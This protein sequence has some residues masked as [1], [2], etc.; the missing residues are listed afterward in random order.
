MQT[1]WC[2]GFIQIHNNPALVEYYWSPFNTTE[3][4]KG[5]FCIVQEVAETHHFNL[6]ICV[7]DRLQGRCQD[8]SWQGEGLN[9]QRSPEVDLGVSRK[10]VEAQGRQRWRWQWEVV[11]RERASRG[12]VTSRNAVEPMVNISNVAVRSLSFELE[13][14]VALYAGL[15]AGRSTVVERHSRWPR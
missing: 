13:F 8:H 14:W 3:D 11:T 15:F 7:A 1:R 5:E 4:P 2:E 10:C 12:S 6:K 9:S